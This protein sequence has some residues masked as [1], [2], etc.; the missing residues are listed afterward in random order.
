MG[1]MPATDI[2]DAHAR[3]DSLRKLDP[4]L[5]LSSLSAQDSLRPRQRPVSSNSILPSL[6][7]SPACPL[8]SRTHVLL[9]VQPTLRITTNKCGIRSGRPISP[10]PTCNTIHHMVP[11]EAA[12]VPDLRL[13]ST[14]GSNTR[15]NR[16]LQDG[17]SRSTRQSVRAK[18]EHW[19]PLNPL[20]SRRTPRSTAT[21][22]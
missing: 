2:A 8:R 21:S 14:L 7:T 4:P 20:L 16:K 3:I 10:H 9:R 6:S 18:A 17:P 13:N 5:P 22:R 12:P 19:N 1:S 15:L 11:P